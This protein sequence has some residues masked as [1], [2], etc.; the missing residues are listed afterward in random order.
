[1]KDFLSRLYCGEIHLCEENGRYL[2]KMRTL[3]RM[4]RGLIEELKEGLD[5]KKLVTLQKF[6]DCQQEICFYNEQNTFA[7]GVSFTARFLISALDL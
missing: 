4:S 3:D 5:E 7:K 6:I 1:M 2:N